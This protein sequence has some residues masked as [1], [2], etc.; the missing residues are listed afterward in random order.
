MLSHC[1]CVVTSFANFKERETTY[2]IRCNKT[3]LDCEIVTQMERNRENPDMI[4][5]IEVEILIIA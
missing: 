1:E 2:I 4:D 5:Y 3:N